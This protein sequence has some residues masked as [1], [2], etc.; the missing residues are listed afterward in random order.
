M[1]DCCGV[2]TVVAMFLEGGWTV[3]SPAALLRPR[4][5]LPR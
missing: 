2:Y 1:F 3:G 4:H 5:A